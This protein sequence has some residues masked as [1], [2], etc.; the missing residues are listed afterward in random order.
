MSLSSNSSLKSIS[1]Q[2]VEAGY[3]VSDAR[4]RKACL[5][6]N[7]NIK[8]ASSSLISEEQLK[9][10]LEKVCVKMGYTPNEKIIVFSCIKYKFKMA[11]AE[12]YTLQLLKSRKQVHDICI[13]SNISVSDEN[14]DKNII[15]TFGNVLCAFNRIK[16]AL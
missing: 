7:F 1:R 15:G 8:K 3:N 11:G 5:S 13:R 4:I 14:L 16:L 12:K 2:I 9:T 10:Y 6:N